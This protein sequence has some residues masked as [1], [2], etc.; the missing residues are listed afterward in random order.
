MINKD[1]RGILKSLISVNNSM[2]VE[3]VMHGADEFKSILFRANLNELEEGIQEF[4]IFDMSSFLSSLDLL[5]DA[6]VELDG[7]TITATDATSTLKFIT[8]DISAL[9]DIA[10]KPSIIDSTIQAPSTLE[11]NFGSELLTRIKKASGVFKT[12]DT[13]FL[14]CDEGNVEV[15]LG[16]KDSFSRSN[17]SFAISVE[18]DMNAGRN[19]ELAIPLE[20]L[21]KVPGMDYTLQVKYNEA[22]DAYRIV[23]NNT[24]LTFIMS[25]M[26]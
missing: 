17:N 24:I 9:E 3:P 23:L 21:L 20:S 12:F 16:S 25:L 1:T 26:K 10:I 7:N 8:S 18:P 6:T 22:K 19:F 13:A 14:I 2:I 11:F 4:G 5:E 15:K